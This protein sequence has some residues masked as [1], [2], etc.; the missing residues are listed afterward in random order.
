MNSLSTGTDG[1]RVDSEGLATC[2]SRLLKKALVGGIAALSLLGQSPEARAE[3][4]LLHTYGSSL[5]QEV[6]SVIAV[7]ASKLLPLLPTG[8]TLL[9]AASLGVGGPDQGI[10]ALVN[11]RGIDPTVDDEKPRKQNQVNIDIGILVV[12]PA[13]AV[14]A[15]VSI[16]GA[17][18]LYLLAIYTDDARYA[19]SLRQADIPVEFVNKISYQRNMND[20]TGVG[21]LIVSVPSKESPLHTFNSGQGYEPDAGA[22][23]AVFWH[24]G[25]NGKAALHFRNQ[26]FRQGTASSRIYTQPNSTWETLFEGGGL[27]SCD[28][29]PE[30]GY[31]CVTAPAFNFRWDGGSD[32]TL[33]L[34]E[35]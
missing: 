9:P 26:P 20:A 31:S 17:F 27:G 10:V 25:G 22:L 24:D 4:E 2:V 18:H 14:E 13:E 8:Y 29:D 12:E 16:P 11:F 28:P 3:V 32:G 5:G 23:N 21:D 35:E 15:G 6:T 7:S 33:V 30:T 34:V 1:V 19:A